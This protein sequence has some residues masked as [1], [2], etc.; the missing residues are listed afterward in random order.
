MLL[1]IYIHTQQSNQSVTMDIEHRELH[2]KEMC[3]DGKAKRVMLEM[4]SCTDT[5]W[6]VLE[7]EVNFFHLQ[8]S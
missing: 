3:V 2:G 5:T 4:M 7:L 6:L 8:G 1:N